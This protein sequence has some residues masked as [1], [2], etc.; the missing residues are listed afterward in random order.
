MRQVLQRLCDVPICVDGGRKSRLAELCGDGEAP[1]CTT[2]AFCGVC[3]GP[4][5]RQRDHCMMN[6]VVT[7]GLKRSFANR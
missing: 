7:G 4:M 1:T 3:N 5:R 6:A 2:V